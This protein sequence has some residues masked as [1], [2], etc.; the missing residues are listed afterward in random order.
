MST[1]PG[2]T[3][4]P[5]ASMCCVAGAVTEPI[6]EVRPS[7]IA[8][9]AVNGRLPVPSTMVPPVMTRS[10]GMSRLRVRC[11]VGDVLGA[12]LGDGLGGG[13]SFVQGGKDG[14]DELLPC[15]AGRVAIG[16]DRRAD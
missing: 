5:S 9:S 15:N 7:S 14:V 8:M 2:I 11:R 3:V 1:N 12:V 13:S 4:A 16:V 6:A 10:C